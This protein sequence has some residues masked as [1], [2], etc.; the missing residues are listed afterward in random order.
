MAVFTV[1]YDLNKQGQ[2]YEAL[3]AELKRTQY[4]H[5]LDSTWLISTSETPRQ[6]SDRLQKH[7]DQND[8][9]IISKINAGEYAGW[10]PKNVW[11][12]IEERL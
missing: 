12:W 9:I 8:H 7:I 2:N 3:W 5:I 1:S 11:T 10:M 4:N 6:I